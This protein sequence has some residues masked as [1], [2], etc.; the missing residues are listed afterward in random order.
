M[1]NI[2]LEDIAFELLHRHNCVVIPS[3]GALLINTVP[4]KLDLDNGSINPPKQS[5]HFN[6][7]LKIDDGLLTAAFSIA[8]NLSYAEAASRITIEV[9]HLKAT[10]KD[11]NK[12]Y[13]NKIGSFILNTEGNIEFVSDKNSD[14]N[15]FEFGLGKISLPILVEEQKPVSPIVNTTPVVPITKKTETKVY[16][17]SVSEKTEKSIAWKWAAAFVPVA[18][19]AAALLTGVHKQNIHMAGYSYFGSENP[20]QYTHRSNLPSLSSIESITEETPSNTNTATVEYSNDKAIFGSSYFLGNPPVAVRL[21]DNSDFAKYQ[22]VG[23]CYQQILNAE[24]AVEIFRS[25]GFDANIVEH[26]KGLFHVSIGES[27]KRQEAIRLLR[28]LQW[29]SGRSAWILKLR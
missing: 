2:R 12:L 10:L 3:F 15:G 9:N 23:G 1:E 11:R 24:K 26:D 18:A 7:S 19:V 27:N 29:E 5:I 22:I 4:A 21:A 13:W 16:T 8:T 17:K 28:K 14:L 25:K 20:I 6:P